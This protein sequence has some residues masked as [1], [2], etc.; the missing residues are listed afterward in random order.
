MTDLAVGGCAV[1]FYS[2]CSRFTCHCQPSLLVY[3]MPFDNVDELSDDADVAAGTGKPAAAKTKAVPP[4]P[5]PE[6]PAPKLAPK[7]KGKSL[8][9]KKPTKPEPMPEA[10]KSE[11]P[12]VSGDA[13]PEATENVAETKTVKK[14]PAAASVPTD[15]EGTPP[16]KRP[17][18]VMKKPS[19]AMLKVTKYW[20]HKKQMIG[21]RVGK[22]EK[23]TVGCCCVA[24]MCFDYGMLFGF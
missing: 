22:H 10:P 19:A 21:I 17:A 12:V 23:L 15:G 8:P 3:T 7:P 16:R 6:K 20:Y 14:R 5:A 1:I 9:K 18:A 2:H 24:S 11:T 13:E 4:A